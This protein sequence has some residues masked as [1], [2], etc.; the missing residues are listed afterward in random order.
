LLKHLQTGAFHVGVELHNIEY[1]YCGGGALP[2]SICSKGAETEDPD[3]SGT[4]AHIPRQHATHVFRESVKIGETRCTFQEVSDIVDKM[5]KQRWTRGKYHV[6]FQNCAHFAAE[7]AIAL[8]V[9]RIPEDLLGVAIT[10]DCVAKRAGSVV[11]QMR[12]IFGNSDGH[13]KINVICCAGSANRPGCF[14]QADGTLEEILPDDS[15]EQQEFYDRVDQTQRDVHGLTLQQY[16]ESVI[17]VG[18]LYCLSLKQLEST[19]LVE[20]QPSYDKTE[21][22]TTTSL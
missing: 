6:F 21:V 14:I 1:M 20:P 19:T 7:L 15:Q 4:V 22:R 16:Q 17:P 10:I 18:E 5:G 3:E 11:E 12:G 9:G 8:G 13:S 2:A